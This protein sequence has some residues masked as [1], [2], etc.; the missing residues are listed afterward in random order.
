MWNKFDEY[1][2]GTNFKAWGISIARFKILSHQTKYQKFKF[3]FHPDTTKLLEREL[4]AESDKRHL[5]NQKDILGR[6][7]KKL[8]G[9]EKEYLSFRY[10][11][12]LTFEGIA[13]RFG[14]SMQAAYKAI[15]MIH[16]RLLKCV[17]LGME[18]EG[19]L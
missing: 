10:E 17:H 4:Q 2:E 8:S 3:H 19:L 14:I 18:N 11:Q 6:C 1:E 13:D 5:E 7:L 15:S 9:K 12:Q 16:A